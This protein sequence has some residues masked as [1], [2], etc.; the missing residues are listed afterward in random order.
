MRRSSIAVP[1][2]PDDPRGRFARY[3]FPGSL[4]RAD[5][6]AVVLTPPTINDP[7]PILI[8]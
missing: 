1:Q 8:A 7:A 6:L 3:N 2:T 4:S 5:A